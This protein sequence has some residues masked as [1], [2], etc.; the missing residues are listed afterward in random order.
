MNRKNMKLKL[1]EEPPVWPVCNE[2]WIGLCD[3]Y[4]MRRYME[5]DDIRHT[6][7]QMRL[8]LSRDAVLRETTWLLEARGDQW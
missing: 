7:E 6:G 1:I 5:T 2:P 4:E 8:S 3:C